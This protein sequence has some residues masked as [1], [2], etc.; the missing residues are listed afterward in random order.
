MIRK[1]V[2]SN[3]MAH[4]HTELKLADGLTVLVGPNNIGKSTVAD[5]DVTPTMDDERP[6]AKI[7]SDLGKAFERFE[8]WRESLVASAELIP[9]T[10][11]TPTDH[12]QSAVDSIKQLQTE[13]ERLF[14]TKQA[15]SDL[16]E[17]P[18]LVPEDAIGDMIRNMQDV[19]SDDTRLD[20]FLAILSKLQPVSATPEDSPTRSVQKCID[21]GR[22][23]TCDTEPNDVS[24]FVEVKQFS[25]LLSIGDPHVEGRTP[26]FRRDNYPETV[27][28]CTT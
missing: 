18:T 1:I 27:N 25:G 21:T 4:A 8:F 20:A 7:A 11:V 14:E 24:V 19:F 2:L 13:I 3:F 5:L 22:P 16:A 10:Q 28:G 9:P 15:A 17:F 23:M 6:L 26:G 12:L